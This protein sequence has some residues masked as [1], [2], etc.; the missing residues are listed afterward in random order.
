MLLGQWNVVMH[1]IGTLRIVIP[2]IRFTF[3]FPG[4]WCSLHGLVFL[5]LFIH[6]LMNERALWSDA[7]V[8]LKLKANSALL[9]AIES[10]LSVGI[11]SQSSAILR[12]VS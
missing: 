3:E 11:A 1:S 5:F 6:N 12:T 4:R 2:Q 7:L 9:A 8:S 10:I